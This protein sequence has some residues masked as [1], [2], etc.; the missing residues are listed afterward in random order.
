MAKPKLLPCECE[1]PMEALI[2]RA[3]FW[4]R[5]TAVLGYRVECFNCHR[6]AREAAC[7]VVAIVAWNTRAKAR[8]QGE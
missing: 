2:V 3:A 8:E 6:A 1:N 5:S 7:K 4:V